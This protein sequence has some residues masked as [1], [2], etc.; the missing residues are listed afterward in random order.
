M[1]AVLTIIIVME[2]TVGATLSKGLNQALATLVANSLAI[3]A[4]EVASLIVPSEEAEFILLVIFVFFVAFA[5]T[6][7]RFIP[8]IKVRF[9][10][11]VSIF[12][13]TFSLVAVSSY[14]IE[15]LMPL[16]LQRTTTIAICLC[17][18]ILVCPV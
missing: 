17:T 10:Y 13:L 5:A 16:A 9:D 14:C 8:E 18:T 1:W 6:F 2:F 4:H 3:G 12:I 11:G 7:S 15:E